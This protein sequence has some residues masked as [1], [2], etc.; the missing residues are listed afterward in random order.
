MDWSIMLAFDAWPRLLLLI[1]LPTVAAFGILTFY[2]P[3]ISPTRASL[4]YLFEPIF[5]A[6]YDYLERGNTLTAVALAGATLIIVA[7]VLVELFGRLRAA[8]KGADE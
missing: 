6:M 2:Q 1:F 3:M 5:A 7:N 8:E 4:L